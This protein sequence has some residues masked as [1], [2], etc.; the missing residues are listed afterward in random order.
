[1][2]YGSISGPEAPLRALFG[3]LYDYFCPLEALANRIGLLPLF[4]R[5]TSS[6]SRSSSSTREARHSALSFGEVSSLMPKRTMSSRR[7]SL[8]CEINSS[9]S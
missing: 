9:L 8:V 1:M 2:S 3:I 4:F 5:L 7:I 6:L